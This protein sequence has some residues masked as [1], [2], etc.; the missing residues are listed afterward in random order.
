M[1]LIGSSH[2]RA[3]KTPGTFLMKKMAAAHTSLR[4]EVQTGNISAR[5]MER[6]L[7]VC[8][9]PPEPNAALIQAA[10]DYCAR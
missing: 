3:K 5:D 7:E 1:K 2:I 10:K 8:E 4:Q 6:L 9:N